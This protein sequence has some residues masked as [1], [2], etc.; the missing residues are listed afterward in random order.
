VRCA[1]LLAALWPLTAWAHPIEPLITGAPMPISRDWVALD[2]GYAVE[3][4]GDAT[5][6]QVPLSV[7]AGIGGWAEIGAS[8]AI[9]SARGAVGPVWVGGKVLFLMEDARGLDLALAVAFGSNQSVR[10]ALLGGRSVAPGFYLQASASVQGFG[11]TSA[12][13]APLHRLLGH[14]RPLHAADDGV[15][16]PGTDLLVAGAA[17]LQWAPRPRLLPTFEVQL[18]RAFANTGDVSSVLLVPELI[19]L[20]QINHLSIKLAVPVGVA[21]PTDI[22]LLGQLDWQR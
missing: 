19:Y 7:A 21:G 2:A 4:A 9:D 20:L 14:A 15:V 17:A 22:G 3:H 6:Q 10:G 18:S 13:P 5:E 11:D 8:I 1:L 12:T 16:P